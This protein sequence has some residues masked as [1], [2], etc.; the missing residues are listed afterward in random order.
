MF[1]GDDE[2]DYFFNDGMHD[3]APSVLGQNILNKVPNT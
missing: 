3:A 2:T 1:G